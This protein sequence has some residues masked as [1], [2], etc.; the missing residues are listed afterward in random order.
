MS[1][2]VPYCIVELRSESELRLLAGRSVSLRWCAELWG[3]SDSARGLHERLRARAD[4][5][6]SPH[7]RAGTTF[8]IE[9]DT[10]GRRFSQREKVEKLEVRRGRTEPNRKRKRY[11]FGA[12]F[13][14]RFDSNQTESET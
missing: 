5:S 8:K 1:F 13:R 3:R 7:L 12:E 11:R 14:L 9:V 10:F 4:L 6:S 2:Q